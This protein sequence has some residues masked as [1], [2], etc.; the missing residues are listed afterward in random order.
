MVSDD[1]EPERRR[2][3]FDAIEERV[4][5]IHGE[6]ELVAADGGTEVHVTMPA[7]AAQR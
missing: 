5:Q 1:A 7:F 2:R 3:S 4:H 6:I